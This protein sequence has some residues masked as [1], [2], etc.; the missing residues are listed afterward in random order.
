MRRAGHH[1]LSLLKTTNS[2]F[3][4]HRWDTGFILPTN[5]TMKLCDEWAGSVLGAFLSSFLFLEGGF[6]EVVE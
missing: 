4:L 3:K 1:G 2:V 6:S 5:C